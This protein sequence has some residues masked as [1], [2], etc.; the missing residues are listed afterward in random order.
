[1]FTW[2]TADT[3]LT[4]F[5]VGVT[6]YFSF[7]TVNPYELGTDDFKAL[8]MRRIGTVFALWS[9]NFGLVGVILAITAFVL[10]LVAM[11]KGHG[12]GGA[13]VVVLSILA[14]II[15]MAT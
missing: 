14:P 10:G 5:A 7:I 2:T 3:V 11:I 6:V 15:G 12:S 8:R 1:M 13:A 9:I 4:L